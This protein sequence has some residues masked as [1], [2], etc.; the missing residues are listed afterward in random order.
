MTKILTRRLAKLP[1]AGKRLCERPISRPNDVFFNVARDS[2]KAANQEEGSV[3]KECTPKSSWIAT[4]P[5]VLRTNR[6]IAGKLSRS[7]VISRSG[8]R[9]PDKLHPLL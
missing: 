9:S 4:R 7:L 6:K 3:E 1:L 8:R 2:Q 5:F